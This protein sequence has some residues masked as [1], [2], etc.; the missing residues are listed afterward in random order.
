MHKTLTILLLA[1]IL[2]Q[3]VAAQST[4]IDAQAVSIPA[5]MAASTETLSTYIAQN[6]STDTARVRAIYV[7]VA[8][9]ISYDVERLKQREKEPKGPPQPVA[10]VLQSRSAVCQG[11]AD[12]FVALCKGVGINAT[13]VSG[14]T[15]KGGVVSPISHA[16]VAAEVDGAWWTFDPTWGAG[17]VRDDRFVKAFNNKF[18]KMHP[19]AILADHMPFDPMLQFLDHPLTNEEF[20]NGRPPATKTVFNYRDSLQ[21][22]QTLTKQ[23]QLEARLR[24]LEAAGVR[25]SLLEEHRQ[26]LKQGLQSFASKDAFEEAG[27]LFKS[28]KDRYQEYLEYRKQRFT[29]IDNAKLRSLMDGMTTDLR[30]ARQTLLDVQPRTDQQRAAKGNNLS[31]LDRF[32]AVLSREKEFVDNYLAGK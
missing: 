23:Q 8:N 14:Y 18:Y 3:S 25:N 21:Q 29:T 32:G 27:T 30:Q 10:D 12:L 15:K 17:Y 11:Y 31:N 24:R 19:F 4:L 6:F 7:W 2:H 20:I 22:F 13:V 26:H 9:N 28:V 5:T 1:V 16:W